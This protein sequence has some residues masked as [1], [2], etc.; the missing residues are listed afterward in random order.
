MS[1]A[2]SIGGS[3]PNA[4][5][6]EEWRRRNDPCSPECDPAVRMNFMARA[7]LPF[8]EPNKPLPI[9]IPGTG[10]GTARL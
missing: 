7:I 10:W 2:A 6:F 3:N 4:M 9:M 5:S 8:L 1:G